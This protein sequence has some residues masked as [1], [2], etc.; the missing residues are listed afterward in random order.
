MARTRLEIVKIS[1]DKDENNRKQ[2]SLDRHQLNESS[3]SD[4]SQPVSG[5]AS[6]SLNNS[7]ENDRVKND[8]VKD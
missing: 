8:N 2:Y 5:I 3:N 4:N 7:S 1:D 6:V